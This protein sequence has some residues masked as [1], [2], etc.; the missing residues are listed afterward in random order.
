MIG[1]LVAFCV[2]CWPKVERGRGGK[3]DEMLIVESSCSPIISSIF[4]AWSSLLVAFARF[5]RRAL[6][7]K[8]VASSNFFWQKSSVQSMGSP[9]ALTILSSKNRGKVSS[10]FD[11][12]SLVTQ[13][14]GLRRDSMKRILKL[15]CCSRN[16]RLEMSTGTSSNDA[17]D[18]TVDE[19]VMTKNFR[20]SSRWRNFLVVSSRAK[21]SRCQI[22]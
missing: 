7:K 20:P 16:M 2:C 19:S 3:F 15:N 9:F 22:G 1:F 8:P 14:D 5:W 21:S 4:E 18:L 6:E 17:H 10:G 13:S 11:E 12:S